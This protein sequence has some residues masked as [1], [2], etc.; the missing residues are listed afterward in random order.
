MNRIDRLNAILIH[1]QGK[2]RVTAQQIADRFDISLRSV[3]RD[4]KALDEAGVPVIGEAGIGYSIMEG[5]RLPPVMFTS[6]EAQSI[7]LAGKFAEKFTSPTVKKQFE[8]A[9]FKIKAVLRATDKENIEKLEETVLVMGPIS[10]RHEGEN[11]YLSDIQRAIIDKKSIRIDYQKLYADKS[12]RVVEPI[13]LCYYAG[14]WHCI[15]WCTLR[16]DYR[17]FKM[18]RIQSLE[19]T[20]VCFETSRH[21]SIKEYIDRMRTEDT[22]HEIVIR[23]KKEMMPY[24]QQHKYYYGFVSEELSGDYVR[25]TFLNGFPDTFCRWV[26]MFTDKVIIESP[27]SI[28]NTVQALCRTLHQH[29]NA[30]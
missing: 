3:Y 7:L 2:K 6:E 8:S 11:K 17:D 12:D 4:I 16:K 18:S 30:S 5:Y 25:I 9:L 14:A 27:Q 19:I 23:I 13:G 1:L 29:Y 28:K 15:A 22:L 26:L 24:I 20:D 10:G 21:P